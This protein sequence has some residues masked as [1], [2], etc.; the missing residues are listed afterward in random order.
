MLITFSI[1][2][3]F[4]KFTLQSLDVIRFNYAGM[5]TEVFDLI[6]EHNSCVNLINLINRLCHTRP[7]K[8]TQLLMKRVNLFGIE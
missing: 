7:R 1:E 4:N 2:C 6:N 3:G 5:R 8:N